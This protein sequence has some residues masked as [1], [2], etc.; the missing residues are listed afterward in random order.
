[1]TRHARVEGF[2]HTGTCH[3]HLCQSTRPLSLS[4]PPSVV[5]LAPNVIPFSKPSGGDALCGG[6]AQR[7]RR[8]GCRSGARSGRVS[9]CHVGWV[10]GSPP[11]SPAASPGCRSAHTPPPK[12]ENTSVT[13]PTG[14]LKRGPLLSGFGQNS[15]TQKSARPMLNRIRFWA[16]ISI[17]WSSCA[18]VP[19]GQA[20]ELNHHARACAGTAFRHTT[21]SW[22][23]C[24]GLHTGF[25]AYTRC[26]P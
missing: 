25:F 4:L 3:C 12:P 21:C 15:F 8:S 10:P 18:A 26:G 5:Y 23:R 24:K 13:S 17:W 11:T 22:F 20:D 9:A 7:R 19:R 1:M 16:D 2:L 14:R 6:S